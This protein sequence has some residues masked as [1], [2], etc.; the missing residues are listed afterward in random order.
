MR[1]GG[2][3]QNNHPSAGT[4]GADQ[5]D[6][7]PVYYSVITNTEID[8]DTVYYEGKTNEVGVER[9]VRG[10]LVRG[11]KTGFVKGTDTHEGKPAARTAVLAKELT[12]EAVF[13]A[14]RQRRNYAVSN[15]RIMLSFKIDGH[16]MGEEIE[17]A[18][19][20]KIDV[21]IQGT[22]AIS[23]VAIVRDDAILH[24]FSPGMEQVEF[25]YVDE[26]FRGNSFYYLRVTQV[27]E[28]KHGNHSH[29]WSSPIW[30]KS[31]VSSPGPP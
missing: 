8:A 2:L 28:D 15:A 14:L 13:D 3:I 10:F 1:H 30:V 4:E 16:E 12:R 29:A 9:T 20:P 23:E 17:K 22:D 6:Y 18:G 5:W 26:S 25:A 7:A 27:D 31:K 19:K 11:G 24:R 21:E